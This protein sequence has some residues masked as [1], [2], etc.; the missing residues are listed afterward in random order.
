[1]PN[2]GSVEEFCKYYKLLHKR[3]D[4]K[5]VYLLRFEDLIYNYEN[6]IHRLEGIIGEKIRNKGAVFKP[7]RSINNT[8]L[9]LKYS[10]YR[11]QF[12][13][14]ENELKEYLYDFET[15]SQIGYTVENVDKVF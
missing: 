7:G 8:K 10:C 5:H 15:N 14:I 11:E 4:L 3:T 12:Q 2:T 6:T 1:M 9:F 13:Y